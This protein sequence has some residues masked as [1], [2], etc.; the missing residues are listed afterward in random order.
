M[1]EEKNAPKKKAKTTSKKP[2]KKSANVDI[3]EVN[4]EEMMKK[5]GE[6]K[7]AKGKTT[8]TKQVKGKKEETNSKKKKKMRTRTKVI[9]AILL[10]LVLAGSALG[11]TIWKNGGGIKG[12]VV[13]AVGGKDEQKLKDLPPL[14]FLLLGK[15]DFMT[16]TIMVC[17]YDPKTQQASMLSVPRDTF[18]GKDKEKA[19]ASD[20]IN[21]RYQ[22]GVDK[23]MLAI[24]R[25]TG[26]EIP[27]YLVVD[28]DALVKLVDAMGGVEF[29]VPIDMDYDDEQ[30]DLYIHLKAGMQKLN[31]DQAEQV[32][33]FRHNN[34]GTTYPQ[35]YGEQDLGRMRT[36]REFLQTAF[37]QFFTISNL[38]NINKFIDIAESSIETNLDF[39]TLKDYVPYAVDFNTENLVTDMLPG[40]PELCNKVWVYIVNKKEATEVVTNLFGEDAIKTPIQDGSTK[41]TTTTKKNNTTTN[42]TTTQKPKNTTET[43]PKNPVTSTIEEPTTTTKPENKPT[44]TNKPANQTTTKT[45]TTAPT[46]TVTKPTNQTKQ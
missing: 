21:S 32:L 13:T 17:S 19:R 16:D 25:V 24:N 4:L 5:K 28:T 8:A 33:R 46:N 26:M 31:G 38:W 37:K 40:T 6:K 34:N 44:N 22:L 23:T 10:V 35:E 3:E 7:A 12:A 36:Q 39:K 41:T 15:S 29:D 9:L 45:N 11:Y 1:K 30:Q 2:T 18:I 43:T 20:K 27:Y 14:Q 42:Q